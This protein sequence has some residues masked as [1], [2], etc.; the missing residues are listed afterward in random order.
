MTRERLPEL[1]GL[2]AI[3]AFFV[4]MY[5]SQALAYWTEA[6]S[7]HFVL[8]WT[9]ALLSTCCPLFFFVSGALALRGRPDVGKCV[10]SAAKLLFLTLFWAAASWPVLQLQHGETITI[11]EWASGVLTLELWRTNVFWFLPVFAM[12]QLVRPIVRAVHDADARLFRYFL[13][14]TLVVSFGYDAV[15]RCLQIAQWLSGSGAP[16]KLAGFIGLF[17]PVD[18]SL[19]WALGYYLLGMWIS[20]RKVGDQDRRVA[21]AIV[22]VLLGPLFLAAYGLI[23]MQ[24]TG[25]GVDVTFGGY[26]F[27]GTAAAVLALYDLLFNLRGRARLERA[28]RFVGENALAVYILPWFVTYPLAQYVLSLSSPIERAIVAVP[29]CLVLIVGAALLGRVLTRTRI[30]KFLLSV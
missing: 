20:E 11:G 29:S 16:M 14:G 23:A 26:G 1:D 22:V 8:V 24:L 12:L 25:S 13:V 27:V 19:S 6:Y 28:A 7:T 10:S 5:H 3:G 4:L 17:R 9:R 15:S 18:G 21:P 30:G 2:K